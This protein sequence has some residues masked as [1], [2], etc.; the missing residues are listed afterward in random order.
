MTNLLKVD[1]SEIPAPED[2]GAAKHLLGAAVAATSLRGTDGQSVDLSILRGRSVVYAYPM[3]GRPDT[4]LPDGWDMLPGARGCT[5]QSCAFRD[6]AHELEQL[7]VS[8]IFGISTQET[9]YQREAAKRLHLPFPLLS[10]GD[11]AFASAMGLPTFQVDGNT[12]LKRLT[13]IIDDGSITSVFYPVFPPD[14][15]AQVV[16]DW[17]RAQSKYIR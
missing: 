12:L 16:I 5:P 17:L 13:L 10:D 3:T 1:W 15:N 4:P 9:D 2:D 11:L 7:G 8:H 14:A 6:H